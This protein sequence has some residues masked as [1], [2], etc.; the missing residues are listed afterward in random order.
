MWPPI[1]FSH[2]LLTDNNLNL[3]VRV[4]L[5]ELAAV[6]GDVERALARYNGGPTGDDVRA[7]YGGDMRLRRYV[8]KI[9]ENAERVV[10]DRLLC[11]WPSLRP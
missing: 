7:E 9:V 4:L 1:D 2:A 11:G 10:R 6:N 3:G 5:P 8:D